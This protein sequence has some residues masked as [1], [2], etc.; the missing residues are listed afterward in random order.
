LNDIRK[1]LVL[2]PAGRVYHH[3]RVE[4]FPEP[5]SR[6]KADYFNI[7]DMVVHDATL[8]L[9][10][11]SE[12]QGMVT[13][14][15]DERLIGWYKTFDAIVVRASNFIHN[16]MDWLHALTIIDRL[17][18]PV[19]A[20]GVG[21]QASGQGSYVLND[22]NLRFWKT[23]AERSTVIGVRGEFSA[24]LLARNGITNT[25]VVGCPTM[26]RSRNRALQLRVPD[27]IERVAFSVR[28]ESDATYTTDVGRYLR[29]QRDL[30]LQTAR[31]FDTTVT[32]HGEIEEKAFYYHDRPGIA[33]ATQQ[34]LSAGWWTPET[35]A[36]MA[37]LYRDRLFFFLKVADYDE[38]IT[39]QDFA[40]GY[41][42]HGVLPAMSLGVPG[43][44]VTYDSRS[45]ELAATHR[46][47]SLAL[48]E[49]GTDVR[50]LLQSVDFSAFN[51]HYAAGYDAMRDAL[52]A[53]GLPHRM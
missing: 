5:F 34:F 42:V 40:L 4:W 3:N 15:I 37:A 13:E 12:A 43:F 17:Q 23:V 35:Q 47:P 21:A 32:I 41:R 19:Y 9:L 25:T 50:Q 51:D 7:G 2:S 45:G 52:E 44:L 39:T 6:I 27:E 18:L 14:R 38:F 1:I 22:H 36:E 30:L 29:V 49:S 26:Y 16:Q 8:Q 53:N 11:F 48:N 46:I 33:K 28:R 10:E 20:I 31:A 24:E